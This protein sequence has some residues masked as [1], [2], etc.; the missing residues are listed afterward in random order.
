MSIREV[1]QTKHIIL[2]QNCKQV[3]RDIFEK[4]FTLFSQKS[5][6]RTALLGTYQK[7]CQKKKLTSFPPGRP[8]LTSPH[9]HQRSATL[10]GVMCELKKISTHQNVEKKKHKSQKK[11]LQIDVVVNGWQALMC[12]YFVQIVRLCWMRSCASARR[13][14]GRAR[15]RRPLRRRTPAVREITSAR[16]LAE[17][18]PFFFFCN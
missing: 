6:I 16:T 11:N 10:C 15:A 18:T 1:L 5:Y 4:S 12:R 13:R 9:V 14:P 17:H 7:R 2:K 3:E 8:L